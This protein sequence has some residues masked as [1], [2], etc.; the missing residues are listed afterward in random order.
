MTDHEHSQIYAA[1]R[2]ENNLDLDADMASLIQSEATSMFCNPRQ[3]RA[4]R[5]FAADIA[6]AHGVAGVRSLYRV[7]SGNGIPLD[8]DDA[9]ADE[10][11]KEQLKDIDKDFRLG[12]ITFCE[13]SGVLD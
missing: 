6:K 8:D 12:A 1:L 5:H 4:G 13:C 10:A 2:D 3:T 9:A 11:L 7:V